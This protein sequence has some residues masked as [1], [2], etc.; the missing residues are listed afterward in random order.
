MA[1]GSEL[2]Y[3]TNASALNMAQTIF[4]NGVTVVSASYTGDNQSSAIYSNGQLAPG[5]VPSDS[6]VILS[7]GRARDFT[8]S[9]GDPNRDP[10]TTTN[11]N[12]IDNNAAFDALAGTDTY[13]ASWLD[14]TFVPTGNLLTMSFVFASEE[15]P[16][17]SGSIFNDVVGIWVNGSL[18]PLTVGNGQAGVGNLNQSQNSNLFVSNVNDDYNTEMDGFTVKLTLNIPV[19]AGQNNTIRIG[20]ADVADYKYDSNLLIAADSAQTSLIAN[21]DLVSM[22]EGTTQTVDLLGNDI[23]STTG[24]LSITH[25]NG[26]AV[27]AGSTVTLATGQVL[28]LNANGTVTI[29]TDA[30]HDTVNFTYDIAA[31]N[32]STVLQTATGI[33]TVET[34][35]C[36]VAGTDILTPAGPKRVEDLHV[37]DLVFTQD[38]GPQPI[39]WIGQ[40]TVPAIGSMAPIRIAQGT[41]GVTKDLWLSPQHR[42]M[43]KGAAA[44]MLFG[45]TEVLAKAKHLVNGQTIRE[46]PGGMVTY[47]HLLFDR[48]QIIYANGLTTESFQPGPET[49]ASFDPEVA[50]ELL[51]LFPELGPDMSDYGPAARMSLRRHE[52]RVLAGNL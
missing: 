8:N 11:T 33:V 44:T 5:V 25:I 31:M 43:I 49:A 22:Q 34:V 7:T 6:G 47:V 30:D 19:L 15:Y 35:P 50:A 10:D 36:F 51:S 12:G 14:V 16:E 13:D 27:T 45:E 2:T 39:R 42:I 40:R 1:T 4:G 3:Q 41:L 9:N 17:Y 18:V 26:I 32:G 52:A 37:G 28:T 21:D 24:T 23:N 38:N 20:I 46:M 29:T 48:H